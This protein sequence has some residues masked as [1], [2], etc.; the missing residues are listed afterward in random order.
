MIKTRR[1]IYNYLHNSI[2]QY[3]LTKTIRSK[4]FNHKELDTKTLNTK[5]I[6]DNMNN[7]PCNYITSLF[8]DP[9]HRHIVTGDISIAQNNK[10][11]KLISK[12]PKYGELVSINFSNCKTEIKK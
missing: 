1:K 7:L 9:N 6:L 5:N 10:L 3:I 8:T 11:R 12:G 4:I 2:K